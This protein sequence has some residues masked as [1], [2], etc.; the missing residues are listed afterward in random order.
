VPSSV[1]SPVTPFVSDE[2]VNTSVP[3]V[4]IESLTPDPVQRTDV[5]TL[6]PVSAADHVTSEVIPTTVSSVAMFTTPVLS[7]TVAHTGGLIEYQSGLIH[8]PVLGSTTTMQAPPSLTRVHMPVAVPH[9]LLV[10][11]TSN[12][13]KATDTTTQFKQPP[14]FKELRARVNKFSGESK[15]DFEMWLADYCEAT[16]DCGWS[17]DLRVRWFSWFLSGVAKHT[18]QRT[19]SKEDRHSGATL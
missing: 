13:A 15:E 11:A 2:R 4:P 12:L 8:Y 9:N 7:G 3:P 6:L 14:A 17:D 10:P 1:E 16:G 19:L 18:W 5:V